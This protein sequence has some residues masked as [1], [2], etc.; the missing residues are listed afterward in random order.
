MKMKVG[1]ESTVHDGWWRQCV[2]R[3]LTGMES[4]D[5]NSATARDGGGV[6]A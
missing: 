1:S 2:T 4:D 3:R 5:S 6:P